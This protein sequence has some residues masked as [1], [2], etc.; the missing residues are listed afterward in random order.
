MNEHRAYLDKTYKG[1]SGAYI[2]N[3]QKR[4]NQAAQ[5]G[6][7]AAIQKLIADSK[8]VGYDLPLNQRIPA[9]QQ[10]QPAQR[11]RQNYIDRGREAAQQ[12]GYNRPAP[13]NPYQDKI[14][15]LIASQQNKGQQGNPA[16]DSANQ[17]L[18]DQL[19]YLKQL[20]EQIANQQM[21]NR[22]EV[23]RPDLD[24]SAQFQTPE[25]FREYADQAAQVQRPAVDRAI[26]QAMSDAATRGEARGLWNSGIQASLENDMRGNIEAQASQNAMSNALAMAQTGM[27]EKGQILGQYNQD[28]GFAENQH[29]F[30]TQ[31]LL[32]QLG[33]QGQLGGQLADAYARERDTAFQQGSQQDNQNM[34]MLQLLGQMG[35]QSIQ[36]QMAQQGQNLDALRAFAQMAQ[37]DDQQGLQEFMAQLEKT[38]V[39]DSLLNSALGR[40]ATVADLT[41]AYQGNF[42]PKY[43]NQLFE[44]GYK[45]K[46]FDQNVK[47]TAWQQQF[48]QQQH[49]DNM[50]LGYSKIASSERMAAQ[51]RAFQKSMQKAVDKSTNP[52]LFANAYTSALATIDGGLTQAGN[53][54]KARQKTINDYN[55]SLNA[56]SGLFSPE[57]MNTLQQLPQIYMDMNGI[58]LQPDKKG[59]SS[60]SGGLFGAGA[61]GDYGAFTG[62]VNRAKKN[63]TDEKGYL[64]MID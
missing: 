5:G 46:V 9:Q 15:Q 62:R 30:D 16:Y 52:Q 50:G 45:N 26:Q 25:G 47:D 23:E 54:Y 55:L 41:G 56:Y 53:D 48:A 17:Q 7:N 43:Q 19:A 28:R 42:T 34:V 57:E 58:A 27:A 11:P 33:M 39:D 13:V 61:D 35:N 31:A 24:M 64:H 1:G 40:D 18:A 29:Q 32:Q 12:G 51:Q 38:K 21:P 3:Q 63:L 14:D 6:D 8:R 59:K 20:Q 2:Q 22:P 49:K 37:M 60:S 36:Q 44:Q 10:Q 4:F